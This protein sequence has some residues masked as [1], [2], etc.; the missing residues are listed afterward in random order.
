MEEKNIIVFGHKNPDTD[1]VCSA[2]LVS[3]AEVKKNRAVDAKVLG[4]LNKETEYVCNFLQIEH[5]PIIESIADSQK[6]IMVDHN[7]F[8]QS[9]QNIENA[10]ILEVYDHHRINN[11][12]TRDQVLMD[13]RPVGCTATILYDRY[14]RIGVE[15]DFEM[16]MLVIS[17]IISDSLLFT[18]P[19]CTELDKET[20]LKLAQEVDIDIYKYGNDMLSAGTN[21]QD[22]TDKEVLNIDAKSFE[23]GE[24]KYF[25]AQINT[26]DIDLLITS[27]GT[28][29]LKELTKIKEDNGF[30]TALFLMTDILNSNSKAYI[31][32]SNE[33]QIVENLNTTVSNHIINLPGVVSRKKQIV[34][35]L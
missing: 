30:N 25:V 2:L 35:F 11:F 22:F 29:F 4:A 17:A 7:E 20:A 5:P 9:V 10:N 33:K 8:S 24:N 21:I 28:G 3:M 6:I 27:R 23:V 31:V 19:T 34:P 15:F 13:I 18:S 26:T 32:G 1:T 14:S 12:R 16:K